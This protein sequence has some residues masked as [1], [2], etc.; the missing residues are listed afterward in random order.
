MRTVLEVIVVN[1][2]EAQIAQRAGAGRLE[3]IAQRERGGFTPDARTIES[4]VA[5]VSIPVNVMVRTHDR[6]FT[7]DAGDR[8]AMVR[9]AKLASSL[10]ATAIVS[11]ALLPDGRVDTDF[12]EELCDAAKLPATFHRAFDEARNPRVAYESL[13]RA[14]M[15][16]RVLTSG[17]AADAW[18]GRA[19]LRELAAVNRP[20]VLAGV[21]IT[22]ENA[23]AIVRD[24]GAGEIH[25]GSGARVR[26]EIDPR[27]IE[28]IIEVLNC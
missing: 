27:S 13:G 12:V 1:A 20:I 3:L 8:E 24:T 28:R 6:G 2:R 11:G 10:G 7:Y 9:D 23:A 18:Q 19:L 14:P 5:A 21:G 25:V 22:A 26:G 17:A 16:T 15:I 4:V